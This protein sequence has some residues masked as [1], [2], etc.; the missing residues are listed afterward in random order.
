M[1]CCVSTLFTF[2]PLPQLILAPHH[3]VLKRSH[4]T[5]FTPGLPSSKITA[6]NGLS[7]GLLNKAILVFNAPFWTSVS[8]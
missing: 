6:L 7:M 3:R 8:V 4:T 1:T 2:S 5:L